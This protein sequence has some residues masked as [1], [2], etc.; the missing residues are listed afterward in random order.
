MVTG[1]RYL[2]TALLG[3]TAVG[4]GLMASPERSIGRD[5][6]L[7]LLSTSQTVLGQPIAYPKEGP[8]KVTAAIV[9]MLPGEETGWHKHE[10]PL[11]GYV[12]EGEI[13]VDYG[14][15]GQ[16]VFRQGDALV[17]GLDVPHNGYNSGKGEARILAVFMGAQGIPNTAMLPQHPA[18]TSAQ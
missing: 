7:S 1:S 10:V 8:A 3:V 2:A 12:L 18:T 4:L 11:F 13:T 6:V 16:H 15:K 17:E 5:Q 9:T 14:P